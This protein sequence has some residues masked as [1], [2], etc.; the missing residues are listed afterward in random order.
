MSVMVYWDQYLEQKHEETEAG[1]GA[2]ESLRD[3]GTLK[4]SKEKTR[5]STKDCADFPSQLVGRLWEQD[6]STQRYWMHPTDA[7]HV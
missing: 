7:A 1:D 2:L 4:S 6:C 5:K 3:R